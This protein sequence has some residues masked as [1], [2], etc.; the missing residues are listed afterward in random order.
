[1]RRQHLAGFGLLLCASALA[2]CAGMPNRQAASVDLAQA[3]SLAAADAPSLAFAAEDGAAKTQAG[4]PLARS[5]APLAGTSPLNG[6]TIHVG[7]LAD[8]EL[9]PKEVVLTFDDGP[10]PGKTRKILDTLDRYGVGA[11]FLMVG[12]MA[13]AY[14]DIAQD[15][16]RRG[17]AIG[18]H[19]ERHKNLRTLSTDAAMAE[20]HEGERSVDAA[21]APAGLE[22]APFFRFPY[23]ADTATLRSRLAGEHTVPIDVDIDSKD[24]FRSTPDTV[25]ARTL[26]AVE[27]QGRGIILFHDIHGRTA[28]ML[29]G[30]LAD[31]QERGYKVVRLAPVP[32]DGVLLASAPSMQVQR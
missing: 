6:R 31:L 9:Q 18:S 2:G 19:T 17:H 8:L 7:A 14:P 26:A 25:R 13:D 3:P 4:F 10:M 24:Y 1:M 15:V 28:A 5:F 32:A 23:L 22:A 30:L 21:L 12:Q 16:A 20:I 27:K 11:T 29:P